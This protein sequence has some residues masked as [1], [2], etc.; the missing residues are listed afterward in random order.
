[1]ISIIE[2]ALPFKLEKHVVA[3]KGRFWL[4]IGD[5]VS[6]EVGSSIVDN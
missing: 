5:I 6:F 3:R 1:M 2:D 4:W